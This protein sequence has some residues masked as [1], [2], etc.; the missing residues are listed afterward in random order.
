MGSLKFPR[1]EFIGTSHP[2]PS[3]KNVVPIHL[4]FLLERQFC[5]IPTTRVQHALVLEPYGGGKR[6]GI[7]PKV[8]WC[9]LENSNII[10]LHIYPNVMISLVLALIFINYIYNFYNVKKKRNKLSKLLFLHTCNGRECNEIFKVILHEKSFYK[11]EHIIM[12][13]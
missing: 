9:Q 5:V 12:F 11:C 6:F 8:I 4:I 1:V 2:N 13:I 10:L 7:N 3:L